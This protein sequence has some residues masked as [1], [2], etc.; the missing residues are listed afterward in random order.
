MRSIDFRNCQLNPF[1]NNKHGVT[2]LTHVTKP[3]GLQYKY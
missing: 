3:V 1:P 2:K